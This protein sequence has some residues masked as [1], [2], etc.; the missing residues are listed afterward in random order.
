MNKEGKTTMTP[1]NIVD[2]VSTPPPPSP[3]L[4]VE[5]QEPAQQLVNPLD[6]YKNKITELVKEK[7]DKDTEL[8]YF[9]ETLPELF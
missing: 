2:L 9:F 4:V 1:E 3:T 5:E 6:L 7:L 8:K